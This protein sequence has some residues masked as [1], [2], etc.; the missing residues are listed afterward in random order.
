MN[1]VI[2]GDF[3]F[4]AAINDA[5]KEDD[6]SRCLISGDPI[7]RNAITLPCGHVF[8]YI[9][10]YKEVR[11]SKRQYNNYDSDPVGRFQMKCP[12]CRQI[13]NNVLPYIPSEG[14]ESRLQGVTGPETMCMKH[15]SC[16]WTF[17]RGKSAGT[18]CGKNAFDSE[19]GH[20]CDGHW[21]RAVKAKKILAEKNN[22]VWTTEMEECFKAN[23]VSAL[24][25]HLQ[26]KGLKTSGLKKD[27][28]IR[29]MTN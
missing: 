13:T 19:H 16:T 26:L 17:K 27:L 1:Y 29:L 10:L 7:T 3:D 21:K 18:A 24:K 12:Y 5:E 4:F 28:V 11:A 22:V 2:E 25:L 14:L 20:L 6:A 15:G 23:K 8:N 9:P